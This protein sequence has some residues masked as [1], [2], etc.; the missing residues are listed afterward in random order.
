MFWHVL[1]MQ[2][3]ARV[4]VNTHTHAHT[5]THAVD[6]VVRVTVMSAALRSGSCALARASSPTFSDTHGETGGKGQSVGLT[7]EHVLSTDGVQGL[8]L[9]GCQVDQR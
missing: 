5:L 1:G 3:H 4:H 2:A 7:E 8:K 9:Q 6:S